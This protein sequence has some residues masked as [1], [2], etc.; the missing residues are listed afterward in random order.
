MRIR[1]AAA[2]GF[3]AAALSV[4]GIT[5]ASA[6]VQ[7]HGPVTNASIGCDTH[8][9]GYCGSQEFQSPSNLVLDV[10]GGHVKAGTA[11]VVWTS[12]STDRATDFY[13]INY[14]GQSGT[15]GPDKTFEYAPNGNRSGLCIS[16][17]STARNTTAVLR[18]CNE[19]IWQTFEPQYVDGVFVSWKNLA[20]GLVITDPNHGSNGT[21]VTQTTDNGN[22]NQH[23]QFTS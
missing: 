15:G 6:S 5:A 7:S 2:A 23:L 22:D 16:F 10:K 14:N 21:Q 4:A 19:L 12:S 13:S 17:P 8:D 18:K 1:T 3:A 11:I 9:S 20:S